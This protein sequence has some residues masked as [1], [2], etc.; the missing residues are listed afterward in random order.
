MCNLAYFDSIYIFFLLVSPIGFD[1]A[2]LRQ[3]IIRDLRNFNQP[4][5]TLELDCSTGILMPL[6]DPDTNMLFLAG[7]G[8]STIAYME[9]MDKDPYLIEGLRHN[10]KFSEISPI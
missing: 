10:G 4:E 9:V 3:I 8:D 6:F 7:K 1:A 2:R 5:K